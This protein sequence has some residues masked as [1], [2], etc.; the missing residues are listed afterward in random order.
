LDDPRPGVGVDPE[1]GLPDVLWCRVPAGPFRM[2]S[3]DDDEIA[4]DSEKPQH[5]N[6]SLTGEYLI[7][8]YPVTNAQF[9]AFVDA[10]GYEEQRYWTEAGWR[11]KGGQTRPSDYGEPV[12]LPNHPVVGVTWYEAVAFCRWLTEQLRQRGELGANWEISLPTESQWE[13]AARGGLQVPSAP[14]IVDRLQPADLGSETPNPLLARCYPW[15]DDPDAERANYR[16]TGIGTTS[17]VGC[18]PGGASPYGVEDLSGNVSE[19]CRTK[20]EKSYHDYREDN[21]LPGYAPRVWRG[22]AFDDGARYVRCA[23]REQGYP[24]LRYYLTV[25]GGVGFRVMAS[26]VHL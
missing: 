24:D 10:G 4:L 14:I 20:W 15:G 16:D 5:R 25:I 7:S 12:N 18:F 23:F 11:W 13:K 17:A 19:W 21:D 9:G 6:D 3:A 2:G 1:T 22:G 26:P 8:R